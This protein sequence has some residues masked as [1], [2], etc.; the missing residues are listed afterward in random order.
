MLYQIIKR[1]WRYVDNGY[2]YIISNDY[3]YVCKTIHDYMLEI[4]V[5]CRYCTKT[6]KNDATLKKHKQFFHRITI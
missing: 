4:R 2:K 5:S 1:L 3:D 6:F